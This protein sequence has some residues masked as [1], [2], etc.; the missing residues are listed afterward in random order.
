V[1]ARV[2]AGFPAVS[3][4]VLTPPKTLRL[5]HRYLVSVRRRADYDHPSPFCHTF[6]TAKEPGWSQSHVAATR[7][8][9]NRHA[10][11]LATK[12]MSSVTSDDVEAAVRSLWSR[13]PQQGRRTLAAISQV[14]DYAMA[15]GRCTAN[16]AQWRIMRV[17]LRAVSP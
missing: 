1:S 14:F 17:S 15:I 9:L 2:V 6:I 16:P 3:G 10:R 7:L 11:A 12:A 5:T 4:G 13:S 8:L